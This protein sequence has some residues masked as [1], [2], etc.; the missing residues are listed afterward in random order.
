MISVEGFK[1]YLKIYEGKGIILYRA[2]R[3]ND[4][5]LV[6]LKQL[7][8]GYPGSDKVSFLYS[9][10]EQ[11]YGP[12]HEGIVKF[13]GIEGCR[14]AQVLV[15]EDFG[16][17]VL[18]NIL[19]EGKT[20]I[21][22][23]L[24]IAIRMAEVL[25]FIH[26]EGIT[27]HHLNPENIF[28][29]LNEDMVKL[30]GFNIHTENS[31]DN[32]II[33]NPQNIYD[34]AYIS[35]EKTGRVM[36]KV[37]HRTDLY[38]LGIIFYEMLTGNLPF[39]SEDY[40]EI[41]HSHLA[42]EAVPVC[43]SSEGIPEVLSDIVCKLMQ[44]K[45]GNRYQTAAGLKHD[46]EVC[47]EKCEFE[48]GRCK[49]QYFP[50]GQDDASEELII[51]EMI[52]D[53]E[54]EIKELLDAFKEVMMD[55]GPGIIFISGHSGVG[56]TRLVNEIAGPVRELG[57]MFIQGKFD[58]YKKNT[59]YEAFIQA[60]DML[61][62]E[63]LAQGKEKIF[64]WKRR[65]TSALG[66]NAGIV[67]YI[68]PRLEKIIGTQE[69]IE[70]L[71]LSE[72][73]NRFNIVLISFFQVMVSR[74]TPLAIFLDDLQWADNSSIKLLELIFSSSEKIHFLII[75]AYRINEVH[76]THPLH[77]FIE[78]LNIKGKNTVDTISLKPLKLGIVQRLVFE[79]LHCS[80][81]KTDMLSRLCHE[82]TG[83]NPFFLYHFIKSLKD[84]GLIFFNHLKKSWEI[85][86]EDILNRSV[87]DNV[88]ELMIR[89]IERLPTKTIEILKLAAC[90]DNTFD[91]GTLSGIQGISCDL[92]AEAL[93]EAVREGLVISE[94]Y[95]TLCDEKDDRVPA[96]YRFLHDRVQ[97]AA[98]TLVGKK[99][100]ED[101]HYRIGMFLLK[102]C[103]QF[104]IAE[105]LMEIADH[106]NFA[107]NAVRESNGIPL[108]TRLN[109]QAGKK[110]KGCSAY[111]R[112]LDYFLQGINT[113]ENDSWNSRYEL[114]L[115]LYIEAVEACYICARYQLM[116]KLGDVVLKKGQTL[117]D[118]ARIYEIRIEYL[119]AQNRLKDAIDTARHILKFFGINIPEK[120]SRLDIMIKYSKIRLALSGRRFDE[121]KKMP[122]MK[123]EKFL[124][125]MRILTGAGISAYTFSA[126][127]MVMLTLNVVHISLKHG[128][129]PSTPT[130]YAGYG[131]ILSA[132]LKK[133]EQG[134]KFGKLAIELQAGM[135][136]KAYD[137]KT[138]LLFEIL[139]RHNRE[140]IGNTLKG[141]PNNHKSGL[142][143]GDLTSAGHVMMQHF[144]YLYLAGRDL[145]HIEKEMEDYMDV[146]KKTGNMTSIFVCRMYLQGIFNL[147]PYSEGQGCNALQNEDF[148][149]WI[150]KGHYFNEEEALNHYKAVNDRTI[151]FN[152][153]FNKMIISYIYGQYHEALGNLEA[154]EEYIDG[155]I[156]TY[157][158]P[159]YHFYSALIRLELLSSSEGMSRISQKRKIIYCLREVKSYYRDAPQ[160]NANKYF[161]IKAERARIDGRIYQA[162][163]YYQES[164][165]K[166]REN[167]FI[168]E[169]ALANEL[170]A[171]YFY[172]LGK[173]ENA[174]NF[175]RDAI[176]CYS[177]WGCIS[178]TKQL[179]ELYKDLFQIKPVNEAM[180]ESVAG[181]EFTTTT[182]IDV[183]TIIRASQAISEEIV[184]YD[185]LKKM[186][187][188][189]LQNA[190]A[191]KALFIMEREGELY[192]EA[193]GNA[194]DRQVEVMKGS[195]VKGNPEIFENLVNYVANTRESVIL[196]SEDEIVSFTSK[197]PHN[198][199]RVKSLLCIPV[200]FKRNLMGILYLEN[201][202]IDGAF[203]GQH[204]LVLRVLT[205][206]LAISME[207]SRLYHSMEKIIDERTEELRSK[208][209]EL[210]CANIGL[211]N[212]NRAKTEFLANISHEMRT[213]LHGVIGMASML[214]K[215][216]LDPEQE[217]TINSIIF[218]SRSLLE[219]INEILDSSKLE[220][221]K[222]ELEEK[223]FDL[224]QLIKEILPSFVLRAEEK[225]IELVCRIQQESMKDLSGDPL[226]IKQIIINLLSNAV[227]FT[228]KGKVELQVSVGESFDSTRVVEIKVQDSG[229]GIPADKL[230]YIF[231][232][233]TQGDSSTARKYGGTGLGLSITR[234][235][236]EM[237]KGTIEVESILG[238]GSTFRC[239]IYLGVNAD[240][241]PFSGGQ[242]HYSQ[243]MAKEDLQYYRSELL[244]IRILVAEDNA[245]G[246]KYIKALLEYLNCHVTIANDGVEVLEKLK[247]GT[248]DCILMDKNMPGLDGIHATR[249]I[250]Q[251]ETG[252]GR[253][254]PI[255]ALTASAIVG[256]RK[257]LLSEGMDYYLSKPID[258]LELAE[259]LMAVKMGSQLKT[260]PGSTDEPD[261]SE[262]INKNVFYEEASLY[263]EEVMLETISEFLEGYE[264]VLQKIE[265]FIG[266]SDFTSAEKGVHRLAGSISIFH[267]S[268]LVNMLKRMEQAAAWKDLDSLRRVY[269]IL[270]DTIVPF[271]NELDEVRK[272]LGGKSQAPDKG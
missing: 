248:Y 1:E 161:L 230:D 119:T 106:L 169:E 78:N 131:H 260:H 223:G 204:M 49:I 267:C 266:N 173:N 158:I 151:I 116:E 68:F 241:S 249:I 219:I 46:L 236:V 103:P 227:K 4:G 27:Y 234:K 75:G 3:E 212:T 16:G 91:I 198:D 251:N 69:P 83:G 211:E 126:P 26:G 25:A 261:K 268:S 88:V 73:Q 10:T 82:K 97:Q 263:G 160:N 15:M 102:R 30:A 262:L 70:D 90:M 171:K 37:D 127:V 155:A 40:L 74:E 157:C 272:V 24:K 62:K 264:D 100:R 153:Y 182:N 52:L 132:Y 134:Y 18:A 93:L 117:L 47:L 148:C 114:T 63:I 257:K 185:L 112:A 164:I 243:D 203:T 123:N 163:A 94:A 129:A 181:S 233:F 179:Q 187:Y 154:A 218:S 220:A 165:S 271:V 143:A 89:K 139:L 237:M 35:P 105:N 140:H 183:E 107:E 199:K 43:Q 53:R 115:E 228:H 22:L 189:F 67:T 118:K 247:D 256:D 235:L 33:S 81:E 210:E 206:Q 80:N 54:E 167:G 84:E 36:Q 124:T 240:A 55:D 98:A 253:H 207:N 201:D 133:R 145:A 175:A 42:R 23:F 21:G 19:H 159:V 255:I 125:I 20:P 232:D 76:K 174:G 202:L 146:L 186:I 104:E 177:K 41:I 113:L 135:K 92:T 85:T 150:L 138:N 6:I 168:Q 99:Q 180:E 254:I 66:T 197:K 213:P 172:S 31:P 259:T 95:D 190:G 101:Y 222:L 108:L 238:K 217:E 38:S 130:A 34:A 110:A 128:I 50:I 48:G 239:R 137:C 245:T 192:I 44:K 111:E 58:Q 162:E 156:G 224:N 144:V 11:E 246:Q 109:L 13:F 170:A 45:V 194:D 225:G 121:L 205:S 86:L 39:E 209:Y 176:Y 147:L 184:L 2:L 64:E 226:R 7:K 29:N 152:S 166:A 77:F 242:G 191:R 17:D 244:S 71:P 32:Q 56:K 221:N 28:V 136:S 61:F 8:S 178:K 60:F 195:A 142:S 141:F 215:G 12:V 265:F 200:E 196:N 120:P 87:T 250:R 51:P 122:E 57:G 59:P 5:T 270:K 258:E 188:I 208:N 269:L 231:Q 14:N 229:I 216:N 96:K 9:E 79:T 65:I 149:P 252:T 214:Q 72:A 193:E